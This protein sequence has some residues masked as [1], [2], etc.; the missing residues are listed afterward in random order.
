[1]PL[2]RALARANRFGLNRIV[3]RVAPWLPG[4]GVVVHVGRRSG[5]V[6]RTPVNVFTGADSRYTFALTYSAKS[7]WVRN[8]RAAA[9]CEVLTRGRRMRLVAPRLV[10]DE[11]RSLVHPIARPVLRLLKVAD[12]LVMEVADQT[13]GRGSY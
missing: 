10:H 12:F 5:A 2:P 11:T 13:G 9:G 8:V 7:D 3:R 4:L 6:Y 1:M